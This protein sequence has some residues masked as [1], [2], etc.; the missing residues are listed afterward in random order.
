M[1]PQARVYFWSCCCSLASSSWSPC[2]TCNAICASAK[3]R[4]VWRAG[5]YSKGCQTRN[6]K[7]VSSG[8][9]SAHESFCNCGRGIELP[10]RRA[11]GVFVREQEIEG[12]YPEISDAIAQMALRS[13]RSWRAFELAKLCGLSER[14]FFRR[15]K[16]VTGTSPIIWLL[17][18]RISLARARL[19]ESSNSIKQIADQVGYKDVFFFCRDFKRHTGFSPSEYRREHAS[20]AN[21]RETPMLSAPRLAN[22]SA[23]P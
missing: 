23:R 13:E 9:R 2:P 7:G 10:H 3:C 15:F 11:L 18:K 19:S 17:R 22:G 20:T 12:V 16:Q 21:G 6:P 5:L 14:H 8:K 4:T 1:N